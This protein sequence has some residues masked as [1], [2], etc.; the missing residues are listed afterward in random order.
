M[1]IITRIVFMEEGDV[2]PPWHVC[3]I[4]AWTS[5]FMSVG[6]QVISLGYP[7]SGLIAASYGGYMAAFLETW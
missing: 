3:K 5:N 2:N 1:T 7:V 4:F 6:P